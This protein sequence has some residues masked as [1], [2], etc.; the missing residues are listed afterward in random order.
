MEALKT[1]FCILYLLV[2]AGLLSLGVSKNRTCSSTSD[3]SDDGELVICR[4][5]VS[6]VGI[7][8]KGVK[9][10]FSFI[11]APLKYDCPTEQDIEAIKNTV[12][13]NNPDFKD[14]VLLSFQ[15]IAD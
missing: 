2:I 9:S 4:F 14:C 13:L 7:K 12:L 10:Y 1:I 8:A 6:G 5:Y 15:R 3:D 11:T